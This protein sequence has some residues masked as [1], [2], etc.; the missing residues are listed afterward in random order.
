VKRVLLD[1][2]VPRKVRMA[3]TD[4]EVRTAYEMGWSGIGP[5][6]LFGVDRSGHTSQDRLLQK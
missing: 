6:A 1:Q 2:C 5:E 3:L 4:C